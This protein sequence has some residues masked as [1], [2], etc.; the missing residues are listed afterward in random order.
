MYNG[1][2]L[3]SGSIRITDPALQALVFDRL[4]MTAQDV[5]HRFGWLLE[6][7]RSGAPPHGGIALGFDRIVMLL[8]G[9]DSLR[10]VI[11]FPKT[12]QARALFEGAPTGVPAADLDALHLKIEP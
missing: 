9:A 8:A 6:G 7:L 4:G 1:A 12:A 2:E 11:A 3:G 5:G 10:E